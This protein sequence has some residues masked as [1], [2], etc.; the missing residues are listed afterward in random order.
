MSQEEWARHDRQTSNQQS[1]IKTSKI[2]KIKN[3]NKI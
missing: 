1:D 2:K 3:S